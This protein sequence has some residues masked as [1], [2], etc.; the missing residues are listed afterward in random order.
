MDLNKESILA[1]IKEEEQELSNLH[2]ILQVKVAL[3]EILIQKIC[4][5]LI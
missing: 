1:K 4:I 3:D 5:N 2:K